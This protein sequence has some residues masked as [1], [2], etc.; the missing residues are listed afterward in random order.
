MNTICRPRETCLGILL[1]KIRRVCRR[2][3]GTGAGSGNSPGA[4]SGECVNAREPANHEL[5]KYNMIWKQIL[6]NIL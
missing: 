2:F 4:G 3:A 6:M 1:V 5:K